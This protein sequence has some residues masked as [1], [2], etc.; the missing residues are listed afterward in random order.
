MQQINQALLHPY[1]PLCTNNA[2]LRN[3]VPAGRKEML[4]VFK[5][6]VLVIKAWDKQTLL[7]I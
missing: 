1:S 2:N 5:E 6:L 4:I 7:V 3:L